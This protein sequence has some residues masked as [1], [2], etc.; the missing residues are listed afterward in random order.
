MTYIEVI[1][2]LIIFG[3]FIT[4]FTQIFFPAYNAMINSKQELYNAKTIEFIAASF[5]N[6]CSR[7]GRDMDKWKNDVAAVKELKEYQITEMVKDNAVWAL[8]LN[9][10]L[11]DRPLEVIGL[12]AP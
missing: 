8:R 7:P 11:Y 3:L 10:V 12:C 2:A 4:G 1:S 9:C 5:R 6:E